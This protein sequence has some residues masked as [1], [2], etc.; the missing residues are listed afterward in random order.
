MGTGDGHKDGNGRL[1]HGGE[2]REA[3]EW[4]L[5]DTEFVPYYFHGDG[6]LST[7]KP[8]GEF[9]ATTYPVRSG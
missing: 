6:T 8:P 9:A 2:W 4:P 1:Y 5:P 7:D 3:S